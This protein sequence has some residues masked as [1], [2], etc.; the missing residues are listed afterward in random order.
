MNCTCDQ[1]FLSGDAGGNTMGDSTIQTA[2][3]IVNLILTFT[4]T[5][6]TGVRFKFKT[7][8]GECN[9]RPSNAQPSPVQ[10]MPN[11]SMV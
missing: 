8:C 1:D 6:L 4:T 3:I 2:L 5:V 10:H 9:V 7:C 11:G